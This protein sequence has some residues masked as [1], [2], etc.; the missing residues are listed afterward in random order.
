MRMLHRKPGRIRSCAGILAAVIIGLNID[1]ATASAYINT[2]YE[3]G[4]ELG[5]GNATYQYSDLVNSYKTSSI[6][7]SRSIINYEIEFYNSELASENYWSI[8][9]Q[10]I[11]LVEKRT[12]LQELKKSYLEYKAT[13]TDASVLAE[14]DSQ[15]DTI[16]TQIQQYDSSIHSYRSSMAEA[17]LQEEIEQFYKNNKA[18]LQLEA[19]NK[20]TNGFLKKCYS[21]ILLKEQQEYYNAYQDYL[22]LVQRVETIKCQKGLANQVSLDTAEANLIKNKVTIE[23]YKA[24]Y[25]STYTYIQSETKISD[26]AKVVLPLSID[27]KEYK[28]EWTITQFENKNASLAQYKYLKQ[29]YQDYLYSNSGSYT[30]Y[31]QIELKIKDY[32]LQYEELKYDIGAYVTDAVNS[33]HNAFLSFASAEKELQLANKN[34]NIAIIKKQHKKA[35]ELEVSKANY[36]TLAAEVTYY[37]C[38]YD[39]IGWQNILDNNLYG[40]TP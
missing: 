9:N 30:L 7:Y 25:T 18:M 17:K 39:I 21:L 40:V 12:Q 19:Q 8:Y 16:D 33:Y 6:A 3:L 10:Y 5:L 13:T 15:I 2:T 35:T 22:T 31:K 28:L 11:D 26:K 32:Q 14:I 20:L 24:S 29:C 1:A 27:K 23:K 4:S 37:Q 34:Y 38:V 36:E